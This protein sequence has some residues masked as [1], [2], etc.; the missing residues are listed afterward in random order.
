VV[1]DTCGDTSREVQR[2]SRPRLH[3]RPTPNQVTEL[4]ISELLYLQN[5][6][7]EK[8]VLMWADTHAPG[9]P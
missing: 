8:P 2:A 3:A 7:Q 5:E 1:D 6:S 9:P 4:I